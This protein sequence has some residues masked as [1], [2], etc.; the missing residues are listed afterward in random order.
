MIEN[1]K[2]LY[3]AKYFR[4]TQSFDDVVEYLNEHPEIELVQ[5]ISDVDNLYSMEDVSTSYILLYKE[6][7]K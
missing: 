1:E 2:C 4:R 6:K 7:S 5:I 3:K